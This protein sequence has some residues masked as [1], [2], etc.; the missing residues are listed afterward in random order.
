MY[1]QGITGE[2]NEGERSHPFSHKQTA[3][4]RTRVIRNCLIKTKFIRIYHIAA[5]LILQPSVCSHRQPDLAADVTAPVG[6]RPCR[7]DR[8]RAWPARRAAPAAAAAGPP[9][10]AAAAAWPGRQ[11][12]A[13]SRPA[14]GYRTEARTPSAGRSVRRG[15]GEGAEGALERGTGGYGC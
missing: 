5:V 2:F 3:M 14:S 8:A 9:A 6:F 11:Q 4:V 12:T 13:A 15:E 10:S 7:P 1:K